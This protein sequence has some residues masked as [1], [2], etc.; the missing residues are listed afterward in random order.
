LESGV[1]GRWSLNNQNIKKS[2]ELVKS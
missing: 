2:H 1:L